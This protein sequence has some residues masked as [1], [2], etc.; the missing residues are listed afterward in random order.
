MYPVNTLQ[1]EYHFL[2][3]VAIIIFLVE[4]HGVPLAYVF[5]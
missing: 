4:L 2:G 1:A 5:V 3:Q